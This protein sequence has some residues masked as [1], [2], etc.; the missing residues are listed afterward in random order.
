MAKKIAKKDEEI[1]KGIDP[2]AT[3]ELSEAELLKQAEE[4]E[5]ERKEAEETE[6]ETQKELK[7]EEQ[8]KERQER[9]AGK[10]QKRV[11]PRHGKKYREITK[12]I[13]ADKE[14]SMDEAI[15]LAL[16]TNPA[17][18]DATVELHVRLHEKEKNIRGMVTLPG[19]V[20]KERKILEVT[21]NNAE[22]AIANVKAGK[23][24]FDI[25][26]ADLKV[27]PK[28]AELAK[29]LGPKGLMPSP[30]AGTAVEDVKKAAEELRGG[31]V[32]YRVDKQNIIHMAIGKISFGAEKISQNYQAILGHLPKRIESI[33]LTTSMGP[34]IRVSRK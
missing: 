6:K 8:A 3:E 28:L 10:T 13:E 34:S 26:I 30:K 33:Y 7:K 25:M 16:Q 20:V 17:K 9:S 29:I 12:Q 18:F 31:K 1:E 22:E 27:M 23:T 32:E 15:V 19:G 24:D 21:E 11:K 5:K 4:R 14:Y 2:A